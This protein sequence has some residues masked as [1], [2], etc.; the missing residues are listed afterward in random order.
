MQFY[1]YFMNA[2][3]VLDIFNNKLVEASKMIGA[4]SA[5]VGVAGAGIGIGN[6][7]NGFLHSFGRN[8]AL[9]KDLF[10]FT[11]LGFALTEAIALFALMMAFLI[12]FL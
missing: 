5:T 1:F 2:P 6:I 12:I 3:I 7:F 8:P 4:G 11:L 9:K 10:V